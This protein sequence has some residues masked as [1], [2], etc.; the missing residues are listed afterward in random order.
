MTRQATLLEKMTLQREKELQWLRSLYLLLGRNP[1]AEF[2]YTTDDDG[3]W[4]RFGAGHNDEINLGWSNDS[5]RTALFEY[6]Q[7]NRPAE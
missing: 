2:G 6:V 5:A 7:K 1:G 3:V 4:L